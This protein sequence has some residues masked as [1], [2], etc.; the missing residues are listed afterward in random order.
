MTTANPFYFKNNTSDPCSNSELHKQTPIAS[1]KRHCYMSRHERSIAAGGCCRE[2]QIKNNTPSFFQEHVP[3]HTPIRL[4]EPW[5]PLFDGGS[6]FSSQRQ[7]SFKRRCMEIRGTLRRHRK[8][9]LTT[10][11]SPRCGPSATVPE[12]REGVRCNV[13]SSANHVSARVPQPPWGPRRSAVSIVAVSI[14]TSKSAISYD[15]AESFVQH[16]TGDYRR[17]TLENLPLEAQTKLK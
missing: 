11:H 15:T 5:R 16:I 6:A 17:P 14:I 8:I 4:N 13:L 1:S 2:C 3:P 9:C 7:L 12:L 10:V